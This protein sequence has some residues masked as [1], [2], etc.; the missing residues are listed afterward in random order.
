M[1]LLG[2]GV[3][4]ALLGMPGSLD[5]YSQP[6]FIAIMMIIGTLNALLWPCF[7]SILGCWF[8][9]KS[10][11]FL[12][13][14]WATCNNTG[15]IFGIQI[16]SVL[17]RAYKEWQ[18]LLYTIGIVVFLWGILLWFFLVPDPEA[19]GISIQEYT[20]EEALVNVAA[21]PEFYE[22]LHYQ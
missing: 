13:G 20:E 11:G 6:Y 2:L 22:S 1:A 12:A 17:I 4:F 16:G 14:L 7:I 10:R 18:Y 8:P 19:I 15:N 5:W 21:K 3:A 9:K